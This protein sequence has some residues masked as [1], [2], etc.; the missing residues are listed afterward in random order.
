MPFYRVTDKGHR[1]VS[2]TIMHWD[3]IPS[4]VR[5]NFNQRKT[6]KDDHANKYDSNMF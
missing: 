3:R 6:Y 2:S 1:V 5:A 4:E